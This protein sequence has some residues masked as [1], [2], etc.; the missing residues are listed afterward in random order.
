M[1][2]VPLRARL[3]DWFDYAVRCAFTLAVWTLVIA[4]LKWAFG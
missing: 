3:S 1:R 2:R 4:F